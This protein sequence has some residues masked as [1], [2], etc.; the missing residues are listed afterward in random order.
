M[1][2]PTATIAEKPLLEKDKVSSPVTGKLG[3]VV[4]LR[5]TEIEPGEIVTFEQAKPNL[6]KPFSKDRAGASDP[7]PSRQDR[8]QNGLRLQASEVADK[9]KLTYQ[10][11][12]AVDRRPGT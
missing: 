5:V 7:R 2:W 6:E 9:L 8:G 4:L 1:K 12:E 10:T 3:K 11:V